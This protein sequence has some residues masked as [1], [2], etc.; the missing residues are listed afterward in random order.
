MV[1][2]SLPLGATGKYLF[3]ALI[4]GTSRQT[5]LSKEGGTAVNPESGGQD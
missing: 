3:V 2:V 5:H 4:A 1:C